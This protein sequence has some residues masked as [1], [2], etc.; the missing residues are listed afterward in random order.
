MSLFVSLVKAAR[1]LIMVYAACPTEKCS[2]SSL[3]Q[4]AT[5]IASQCNSFFSFK[6]AIFT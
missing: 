5:T 3:S 1:L 2:N 4:N 6:N